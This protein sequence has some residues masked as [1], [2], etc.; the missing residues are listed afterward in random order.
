MVKK[1]GSGSSR[2]KYNQRGGNGGRP[3]GNM[4]D[5][6]NRSQMSS[7]NG[8]QQRQ[9]N[10]GGYGSGG[11]GAG[12]QSRLGRN[13]TQ[14]VQPMS[15]FSSAPTA[16]TAAY[17]PRAYG[18]GIAVGS[19]DSSSK[20]AY[21]PRPMNGAASYYDAVANGTSASSNHTRV[22]ST[23][24]SKYVGFQS[25]KPPP[26]P[27]AAMASVYGQQ[28]HQTY[29]SAM[30]TSAPSSIY[31]LPPPPFSSVQSG[32]PFSYPPPVLPVKN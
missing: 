14:S 16:G 25:A 22:A 2:N 20:P 15:R 32:L 8:F 3:N 31:S 11:G 12:Q 29:P 4:N 10:G 6:R 18:N 26:P 27:A 17:Q 13:P 23:E 21:A 1:G 28:S 5:Y 19:N 30:A 9:A 7:S 24:Q